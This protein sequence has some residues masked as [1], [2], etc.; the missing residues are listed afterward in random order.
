[1]DLETLDGTTIDAA[2]DALTGG[3]LC[4]TAAVAAGKDWTAADWTELDGTT[5]D[6]VLPLTQLNDA[7]KLVCCRR[8]IRFGLGPPVGRRRRRHSSLSAATVISPRRFTGCVPAARAASSAVP[9]DFCRPDRALV[10]RGAEVDALAMS[11]GRRP[12]AAAAAANTPGQMTGRTN[13][14]RTPAAPPG[15]SGPLVAGGV[16]MFGWARRP[17]GGGILA[18]A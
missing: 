18:P 15:I 5:Y 16:R 10:S 9:E 6:A 3:G 17:H 14:P 8:R 13:G 1:M 4:C 7:S 2:D 12:A 11:G